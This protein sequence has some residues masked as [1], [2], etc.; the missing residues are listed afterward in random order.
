MRL[1]NAQVPPCNWASNLT[2]VDLG[3]SILLLLKTV[4]VSAREPASSTSEPTSRRRFD[5]ARSDSLVT[6]LAPM[7]VPSAAGAGAHGDRDRY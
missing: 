3:R 6:R 7:S 1:K 5:S 2:F 4:P